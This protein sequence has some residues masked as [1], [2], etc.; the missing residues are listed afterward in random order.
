MKKKCPKANWVSPRRGGSLKCVTSWNKISSKKCVAKCRNLNLGLTTKAKVC[1]STGQE[2]DPGVW[3]SVKMNIHTPKWTLMLGVGVPVD[4]WIFRER[5]Q[6]SKPIALMSLYII[7][8]L[9]KQRCIKWVCMTHLDIW[10]INYGQKKGRKLNWQF[11][12]RP[13]KL[14]N[15]PDVLA[16]RWHATC[17]WKALDKGYNF[18]SNLIMIGGLC[19][20][21]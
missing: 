13:Q 21:L 1:K 20:K 11:D 17:C 5:L 3:E 15:R 6:K 8:K 18:A 7:G 14:E 4:S 12:S 16:R 10:N 19:K 2:R 9:L